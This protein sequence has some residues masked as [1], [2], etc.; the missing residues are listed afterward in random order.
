MKRWSRLAATLLGLA[1]LLGLVVIPVGAAG[2]QAPG[3]IA[4]AILGGGTPEGLGDWDGG[5]GLL[6]HTECDITA[7]SSLCAGS[8]GNSASVHVQGVGVWI[9]TIEWEITGGTFTSPHEVTGLHVTSYNHTVT[10][11]VNPG[12][13]QVRL[14][15][16]VNQ[17]LC[18]S[19]TCTKCVPVIDCC[20]VKVRVDDKVVCEDTLPAILEAKV[21]GTT[22]PGKTYSWTGPGGFTASTA[23]ISVSTA[24]TYRVTVNC[25]NGCDDSDGGTLV[26]VGT[27]QPT[28]P[29]VRLC[30]GYTSWQ[31][32]NAVLAAGG[33]CD[34]GTRTITDNHNG[35]YTV[36]CCNNTVLKSLDCVYP[37]C[38]AEATG[39]IT[40]VKPPVCKITGPSTGCEGVKATY[41]DGGS[42]ATAW[43]WTVTGGTFTGDGTSSIEVTWGATAPWKVALK[44]TNECGWR[45]CWVPV[46]VKASRP[47]TLQGLRKRPLASK[48]PTPILVTAL[49]SGVGR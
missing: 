24:G 17:N 29:D 19:S 49:P 44:V 39:N 34:Y 33:G 46:T 31:L 6:C 1:L 47:A 37:T 18:Y 4:N 5:P 16:Y 11:S 13:T 25:T 22:C 3:E 10:F 30:A 7:P 21:T 48:R 8:T 28:A 40:V 12:V 20:D 43:D 14:K 35:T 26:V 38:C 9:Y 41:S 15:V 36:K 27:P 45:E 42:G 32:R 23:S 2:G